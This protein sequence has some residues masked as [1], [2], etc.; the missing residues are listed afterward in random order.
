LVDYVLAGLILILTGIVV[1]VI[2]LIMSS[3]PGE[4]SLGGGAVILVGPV[5]I[6]FGS[7]ARWTSIAI[8]LAIALVLLTLIFYL[9]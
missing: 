5:P 2:G 3:K 4:R 8:V 9:T 7:D 1:T 6:A